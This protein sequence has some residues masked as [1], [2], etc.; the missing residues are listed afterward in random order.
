MLGL[1]QHA[2]ILRRGLVTFQ[3]SHQQ[4]ALDQKPL[5][6]VRSEMMLKKLNPAELHFMHTVTSTNQELYEHED[7][8]V[9]IEFS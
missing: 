1:I 6:K 7:S 3:L 4:L 9:K 5:Q 8:A 2:R